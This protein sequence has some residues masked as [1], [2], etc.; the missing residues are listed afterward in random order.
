MDNIHFFIGAGASTAF[1]FPSMKR[2]TTDFEKI[3]QNHEFK[4]LFKSYG[5]ILSH[6]NKI[7]DNKP[8]IESIMSVITNLKDKERYSE[9]L[10]DFA[11]FTLNLVSDINDTY[12]KFDEYRQNLEVLEK[13]YKIFIRSQMKLTSAKID[14]IY[15]IYD[16]FF[17]CLH[18]L[19][20]N[21]DIESDVK[22]YSQIDKSSRNLHKIFNFFTTIMILR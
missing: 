1:G 16:N 9:N 3:I 22:P 14:K 17:G 19:D 12:S 18:K 20:T 8:D 10:G 15:E 21:N 6:M 7:F 11:L 13:E 4:T 2:L 5:K